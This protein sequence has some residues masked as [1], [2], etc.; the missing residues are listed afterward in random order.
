MAGGGHLRAAGEPARR[1]EQAVCV[2]VAGDDA[3]VEP[4]GGRSSGVH[5][6]SVRR[7]RRGHRWVLRPPGGALSTVTRSVAALGDGGQGG[8][9]AR[10]FTSS[11]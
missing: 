1:V 3:G 10:E 7:H 6:N 4:G 11:T 9:L 2:G 8:D 5:G